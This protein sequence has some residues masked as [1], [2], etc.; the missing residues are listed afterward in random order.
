MA[1]KRAQRRKQCVGKVKHSCAA[2]A[3]I[4]RR[5]MIRKIGALFAGNLIT[6]HCKL[7]G[8]WHV[9]HEPWH[10]TMARGEVLQKREYR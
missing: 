10:V 7:C 2:H 5:K 4:A 9:G 1:S 6:Y 8:F 3:A